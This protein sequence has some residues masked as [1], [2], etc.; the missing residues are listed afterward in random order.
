MFMVLPIFCISH[1]V[2]TDF[3]LGTSRSVFKHIAYIG[4]QS[5]E[6]FILYAHSLRENEVCM[7]NIN[8]S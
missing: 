5:T 6:L 4:E 2:H 7:R 3:V 8:K 1:S